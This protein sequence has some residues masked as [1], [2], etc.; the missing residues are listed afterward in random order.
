[1]V[2]SRPHISAQKK[3]AKLE[4]LVKLAKLVKLVSWENLTKVA[5]LEEMEEM[6][7]FEGTICENSVYLMCREERKGGRDH[8][9]IR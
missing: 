7:K 2:S 3:V 4:K 1:M 8:Q 6:E 5:K 9:K